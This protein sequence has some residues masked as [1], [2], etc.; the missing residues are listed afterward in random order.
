MQDK[1]ILNKIISDSE[2]WWLTIM[3]D[4]SRVD[5]VA[6]IH[7]NPTYATMLYLQN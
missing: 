5:N 6:L 7:L 1:K 3:I 4:A 2:V